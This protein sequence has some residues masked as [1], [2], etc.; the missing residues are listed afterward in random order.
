MNEEIVIIFQR[1]A[2]PHIFPARVIKVC[3]NN[4]NPIY[5]QILLICTCIP[6]CIYAKYLVSPCCHLLE[7]FLDNAANKERAVN[8]LVSQQSAITTH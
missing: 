1:H 5:S 2:Q 6:Y 4:K 8:A 3:S 7:M